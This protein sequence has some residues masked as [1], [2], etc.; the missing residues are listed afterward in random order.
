MGC[1]KEV[2]SPEEVLAQLK[3]SP[4]EIMRRE[5]EVDDEEDTLVIKVCVCCRRR[6]A[7]DGDYC[8]EFCKVADELKGI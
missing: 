7:V 8:G 2:D 1:E 3:S 5:S 4:W 6:T